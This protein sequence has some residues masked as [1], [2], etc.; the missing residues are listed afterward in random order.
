[1]IKSLSQ[2]E[3]LK[4]DSLEREKEMLKHFDNLLLSVPASDSQLSPQ[5]RHQSIFCQVHCG[6]TNQLQVQSTDPILAWTVNFGLALNE[7]I[8]TT[9][10]DGLQ[11]FAFSPD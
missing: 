10:S 2:E 11:R 7:T 6:S 9:P 1:M 5:P 8:A 4:R 3:W